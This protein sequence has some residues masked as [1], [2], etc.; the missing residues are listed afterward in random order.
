MWRKSHRA[1]QTLNFA[2]QITVPWVASLAKDSHTPTTS[3]QASVGVGTTAVLLA[4][5]CVAACNEAKEQ[6]GATFSPKARRE[7]RGRK[8]VLVENGAAVN[9]LFTGAGAD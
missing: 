8:R 4:F 5:F 6:V 3:S 1:R 7:G 9:A 2:I